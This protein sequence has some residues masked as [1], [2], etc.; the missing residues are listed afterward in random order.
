MHNVRARRVEECKDF[1][2]WLAARYINVVRY[3]K[4][5]KAPN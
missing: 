5:R 4:G 2:I 3:I 1:I